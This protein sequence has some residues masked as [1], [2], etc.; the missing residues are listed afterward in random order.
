MQ[1]L[2]HLLKANIGTGLMGLPY[3]VH[4]AGLIV[5]PLGLLFMAVICVFCMDKLVR[6]AHYLCRRTQKSSLDYGEVAE[7]AMRASPFDALKRKARV[8][9]FV[10]NLFLVLT[11]T[12]FCCVSLLYVVD[13]IYRIWYIYVNDSVPDIRF[14][15]LMLLPVV[16]MYAYIRYLDHLAPFSTA[17]NALSVI[18]L[19]IIFEYMFYYLINEASPKQIGNLPYATDFKGMCLFYGSAIY[20]FEGIGVVLPLE[21]KMKNQ[22]KFRKVLILG[23]GIVYFIYLSMGLLGYL[24]FGQ[25]YW[26][27]GFLYNVT[28]DLPDTLLYILVR[29]M[30]ILVI[31]FT[32]GIQFY[33]PVNILWPSIKRRI[34]NERYRGNLGEYVFRTVLVLLTVALATCVLSRWYFGVIQFLISLIGSFSSTALALI[35][36]PLLEELTLYTKGYSSPYPV[37]RL[38]ANMCIVAFGLMGFG[39]VTY[40]NIVGYDIPMAMT[41]APAT[42]TTNASVIDNLVS[43]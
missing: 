20:A 10:V 25:N 43:I 23:M 2:M 40:V 34:R 17:A 14:I 11:Q 35:F 4:H 8:G 32:Y 31:F 41:T 9:R 36:P 21:N 13:G 28:Q 6:C 15:V 16:L 22:D 3:T 12:G 19:V 7:E 37:A 38:V 1:T 29:M 18:G 39:A 27:W 33:V 24:C 5:G 30:F 26:S 42:P